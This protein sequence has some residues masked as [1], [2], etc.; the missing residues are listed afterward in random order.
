MNPFT[1]YA[2]AGAL[3]LPLYASAQ[4][5]INGNALTAHGKLGSTTNYNISVITNNTERMNISGSG[6][7][8]FPGLS[9]TGNGFIKLSST[10]EISRLGFSGTATDVL[11]GDATF[12]PI[13]NLTGWLVGSGKTT[14]TAKVGIGISSPSKELEVGGDIAASGTVFAQKF[15]VMDVSSV[16]GSIAFTSN[17][18][19]TGYDPSAFTRNAVYSSTQPFYLQSETAYDM[20]TLINSGNAGKVGIGT[21]SPAEKLHVVGNT[22]LQGDLEITGQTIH[23][24]KSRFY[25]ISGIAGDSVIRFGDS[26]ILMNYTTNTIYGSPSTSI[27]AVNK[28]LGLGSFAANGKGTYT[29]AIGYQSQAISN[30]SYSMGN[31]VKTTAEQAI[32]IGAGA[33]G[34]AYLDNNVSK[35]IMFATGSDKATMYLSPSAGAGTT[36]SVGIGTTCTPYTLTVEGSIGSRDVWVKATSWC[37]YVFSPEHQRMNLNELE[38]YINEHKHLPN[39]PSEK[40]IVAEGA[41]SVEQTSKIYMEKIEELTLYLIEMNKRL[42]ALEKENTALKAATNGTNK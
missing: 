24:G 1:R 14:T 30:R 3:S 12:A 19:L 23:T 34:G 32:S 8:K 13:Y 39:V 37:D 18:Y 10:G 20:N 28:G 9:G 4:W 29:V 36:G 35:S 42:E 25:R 33:S 31:F 7:I 40:E 41:F 27:F 6:V 38:A 16:N 17:M 11:T 21:G 26:T 15:T 2:L 5:G 22:K